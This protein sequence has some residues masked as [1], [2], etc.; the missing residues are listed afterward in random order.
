MVEVAQAAGKNAK[1]LRRK[2]EFKGKRRSYGVDRENEELIVRSLKAVEPKI[3]IWAE[4]GKQI[5]DLAKLYSNRPTR[6]YRNFLEG[7]PYSVMIAYYEEKIAK[8]A[9]VYAPQTDEHLQLN[10][11]KGFVNGEKNLYKHKNF[12]RRCVNFSK[13]NN[14]PRSLKPLGLK[15]WIFVDYAQSWRILELL[16]RILSCSTR[17]S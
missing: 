8:F 11:G 12:F 6:R 4:S 13:S 2:A 10:L 17:E 9:V 16:N 14:Y 5:I 1:I 3:S 15:L 7:L